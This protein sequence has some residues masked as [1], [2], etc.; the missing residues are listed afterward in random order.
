[1][2]L[3]LTDPEKVMA[4][5]D[6]SEDHKKALLMNIKKKMATAPIKLR[7]TFKLICYNFDGVI[8][9]KEALLAAKAQTTSEKFELVFQMI[10]SPE[11]KVEV[12]T[13]DKEG[14]TAKLIEATELVQKEIKAR[15]GQFAMIEGPHVVGTDQ[16]F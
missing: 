13:L 5:L 11:Y 4:E 10:V 2:K 14:G 7:T 16:K 1:M 12:V 3:C 9:I 15:G 8:A 6:I